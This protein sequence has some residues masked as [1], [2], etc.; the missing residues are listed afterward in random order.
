[1]R[2]T[3]RSQA[4]RFFFRGPSSA[5]VVTGLAVAVFAFGAIALLARVEAVGFATVRPRRVAVRILRDAIG[6]FALEAVDLV[7]V[8][9]SVDDGALRF[10]V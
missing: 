9:T 10:S 8:W 3:L 6:C 7:S 1:M 4:G 5:A 2:P